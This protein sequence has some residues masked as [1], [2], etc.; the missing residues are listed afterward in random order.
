MKYKEEDYIIDD[1]PYDLSKHSQ[2]EILEMLLT[3]F[4]L[5]ELKECGF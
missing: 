5:E 1:K 2:E 3:F 4:T